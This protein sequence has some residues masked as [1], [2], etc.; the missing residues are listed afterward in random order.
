MSVGNR[1]KTYIKTLLKETVDEKT[2]EV[3]SHTKEVELIKEAN[4]PTF[5][6]MNISDITYLRALTKDK[7]L[8]LFLLAYN[9]NQHDNSINLNVAFIDEIAAFIDT[10]RK[11]VRLK[12]KELEKDLFI[13]RIW[14]GKYYLNP[15]SFILR[16]LKYHKLNINNF[17]KA[18]ESRMRNV[19][20]HTKG[21]GFAKEWNLDTQVNDDIKEEYND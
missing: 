10:S 7:L 13:V 19:E 9:A 20:Q 8:I 18:V 11:T 6:M 12:I 15:C 14:G 17:N 4:L 21:K 2:G 1:N 5:M 16:G 3:V